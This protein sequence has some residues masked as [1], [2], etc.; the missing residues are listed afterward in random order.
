MDVVVT[1][2]VVL[3]QLITLDELMAKVDTEDLVREVFKLNPAI[4]QTAKI[5]SIMMGKREG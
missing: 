3:P 2:E 5:K 4:V 1:L